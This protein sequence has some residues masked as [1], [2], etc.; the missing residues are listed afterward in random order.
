MERIRRTA[1]SLGGLRSASA[2]LA[3]ISLGVAGPTPGPAPWDPDRARAMFLAPMKDTTGLQPVWSVA[4]GDSGRRIEVVSNHFWESA[5]GHFP[6]DSIE[7]RRF[8]VR[9]SRERG[10]EML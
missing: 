6:L 8:T 9:G 7:A 10:E 5:S 4:L 3:I 2:L 1:S